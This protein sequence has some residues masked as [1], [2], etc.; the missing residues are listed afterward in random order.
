MKQ[1]GCLH[2]D[3]SLVYI[4]VNT[5]DLFALIATSPHLLHEIFMYLHIHVD[6]FVRKSQII[7]TIISYEI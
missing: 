2:C 4:L 5:I 7:I 3:Q 6:L 1:F